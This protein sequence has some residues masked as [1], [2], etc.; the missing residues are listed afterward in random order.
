MKTVLIV[1]DHPLV[2]SALTQQLASLLPGVTVLAAD[3]VEI[4]ERTAAQA[5]VLDLI[6]LDINLPDGD[7]VAL[8]RQWQ[9][10]IPDVPVIVVSGESEDEAA[11]RAKN[12][13]AISFVAKSAPECALRDAI[14][15]ALKL[16]TVT[17]N[18]DSFSVFDTLTARQQAV[19]R[20]LVAGM[21]NLDIANHMDISELTVK[22][23]LTAI[24]KALGVVSRTQAVLAARAAGW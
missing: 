2:R 15:K 12:A 7:G 24:F 9:A 20:A 8:L 17:G 4:A 21:S 6:I 16:S 18:A 22:A 13:G 1:D 5:Q 3:S 11:Q 14:G 23:H 10:N 19:L